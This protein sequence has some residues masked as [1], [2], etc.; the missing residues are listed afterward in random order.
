MELD[1]RLLRQFAEVANGNRET[2]EAENTAYGTVV[3]NGEVT[4][5][6]LDGTELLTPVSMAMDAEDGDRRWL[7][8]I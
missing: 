6:R 3:K 4:Y 5:V 2:G 7:C 1:S 8:W